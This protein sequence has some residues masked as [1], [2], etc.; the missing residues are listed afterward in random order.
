MRRLITLT[1]LMSLLVGAPAFAVSGS[2]SVTPASISASLQSTLPQTLLWSV[3]LSGVGATTNGIPLVL[4]SPQATIST[5]SG[6]VL[7]LVPSV[8]NVRLGATGQGTAA[9]TLTISP[10]TIATALRLGANTL[11][12]RRS[13]GVP[14]YG[15]TGTLTISLGGGMAGPL[16]VARVELHFDDRALRRVVRPGDSAV[17]IAE[18]NYTG[19]GILS[20]LWE[21]ASPPST[22][23]QPVFVPLASAAVNLGGGGL[24]E[25]TSPP[26]PATA[27][28]AYLVRF[29]VR[30]PLVPFDGLVLQ[31]AVEASDAVV[32][33][34]TVLGPEQH[35]TLSSVTRFEW[36][37]AAGA[38]AY[39]IEFFDAGPVGEE[40]RPV[41]GQWVTGASR[42]AALSVLAQTHLAGGQL[43]RWRVVA[44]DGDQQVVGRSAFYEIRTP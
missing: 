18:I 15:A 12:L 28:G 24:T 1:A 25:V 44:L 42:N 36:L 41:S 26:L 38:I 31:Y 23:G 11:L 27:A 16:T 34:I 21:V 7:Q 30:S 39:R 19:T 9:E 8:L 3:S 6:Q 17:A 32:A 29:R 22:L 2:A 13:F 43:F 14:P 10:G 33:P 20:G 5:P 4:T 35:A 40:S 37:P